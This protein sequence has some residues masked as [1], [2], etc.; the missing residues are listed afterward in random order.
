VRQSLVGEAVLATIPR[1]RQAARIVRHQGEWF[2][3]QAP[4]G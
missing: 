3:G 4:T 1:L 2:N